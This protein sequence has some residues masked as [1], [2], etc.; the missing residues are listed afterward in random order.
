MKDQRLEVQADPLVVLVSCDLF[1][2][3]ISSGEVNFSARGTFTVLAILT[4]HSTYPKGRGPVT[5]SLYL[6]FL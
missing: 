1:G 5:R 4:M 2:A 3:T 6:H